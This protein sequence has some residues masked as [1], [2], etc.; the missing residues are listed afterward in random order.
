[1]RIL[2]DTNVL[3]SGLISPS[4][5]PGQLV[6]AWQDGAFSLVL[7][8]QQL[9]EIA[10]VLEYPRIAERTKRARS[11]ALLETLQ[12]HVVEIGTL[13]IVNLSP[14]PDD[15]LIL[16]AAI[17]GKADLIVSGDKRD[18]LSLTKINE[19]PIVTAKDALQHLGNSG[20]SPSG[21]PPSTRL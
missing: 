16:A 3:V 17:A 11:A 6:S 1:M 18:L 20:G 12:S 4:G 15:N 13:P 19:I 8:D 2:L 7:S 14:D 21:H 10:R 9:T 5:P